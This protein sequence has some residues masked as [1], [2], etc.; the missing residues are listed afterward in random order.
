LLRRLP[1]GALADGVAGCPARL[2]KLLHALPLFGRKDNHGFGTKALFCKAAAD[3]D[4]VTGLDVRMVD[5]FR[6]LCEGGVFVDFERLVTLSARNTVSFGA[7]TDHYTCNEVLAHFAEFPPR[8][9]S[10][11]HYD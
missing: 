6:D 2:G 11:T 5:A 3:D 9:P 7:S 10:R 4:M 8:L 1:A